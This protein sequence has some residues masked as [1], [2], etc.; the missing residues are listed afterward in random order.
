LNSPPLSAAS[1]IN[2]LLNCVET[3]ALKNGYQCIE[4]AAHAATR[5][6]TFFTSI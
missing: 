1:G 4:G 5:D 2:I 6:S 3:S